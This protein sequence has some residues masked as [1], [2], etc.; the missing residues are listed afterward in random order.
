[1]IRPSAPGIG[2]TPNAIVAVPIKTPITSTAPRRADANNFLTELP[3]QI[4]D[5]TRSATDITVK[6][7]V[8]GFRFP[9]E[10][11]WG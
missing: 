5:P 3:F 6:V 10:T 7:H 11:Y 9:C 2:T 4:L 1:L 8:R